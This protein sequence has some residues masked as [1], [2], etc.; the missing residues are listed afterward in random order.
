M[1]LGKKHLWKVLYRDCSFHFDPLT[2][3]AATGNSCFRL[4]YL[5]FFFSETA[6]PKR[7]E[8]WWESPIGSGRFCIKFPQ[9]R[10]KDE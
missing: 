8:I 3:M 2:N 4:V 9:S 6:L 7:T 5:K 10:M 1:K